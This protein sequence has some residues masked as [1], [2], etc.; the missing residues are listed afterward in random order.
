MT[1]QRALVPVDQTPFSWTALPHVARLAVPEVIL[2]TVVGSVAEEMA[3]RGPVAEIPRDLAHGL[4]EEASASSRRLL[5]EAERE[6]RD[7]GWRGIARHEL[8]PGQPGPEIVAGAEALECDVVV[9]ATHGRSGLAR[10]MQRSVADYVV[11]HSR[12]RAVLLIL[13]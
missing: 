12:S 1:Y 4:R 7:L 3:R 10:V 8:R 13:A 2:F 11:T 9:M 5:Y 6:L